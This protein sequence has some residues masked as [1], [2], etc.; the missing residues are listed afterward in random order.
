MKNGTQ[1]RST[2]SLVKSLE[3][4]IQDSIRLKAHEHALFVGSIFMY[5]YE[6]GFVHGYKHGKE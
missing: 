4:V 2:S 6:E 3:V 5:G 1:K